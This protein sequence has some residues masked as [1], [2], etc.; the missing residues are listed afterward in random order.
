MAQCHEL[1]ISKMKLAPDN[2]KVLAQQRYQNL[3]VMRHTAR[4]QARAYHAG[5]R[6]FLTS[7]RAPQLS[8]GAKRAIEEVAGVEFRPAK[9]DVKALYGAQQLTCLKYQAR[10]R[11]R[12]AYAH[13]GIA[14]KRDRAT[15]QHPIARRKL[16]QLLTSSA[17][18]AE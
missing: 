17:L 5:D 11:N 4:S 16:R 2:C 7:S 13:T 10:L 15:N 9:G 3:I 14:N 6:Y 12:S 1:Q 18:F 8:R